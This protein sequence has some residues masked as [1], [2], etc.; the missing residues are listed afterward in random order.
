MAPPA[1]SGEPK[2][3]Q[4][5]ESGSVILEVMVTNTDPAKTKW[6]LNDKEL[7]ETESYAF[8]SKDEGGKRH[9]LKCEIKNFDKPLAG[10][11]KATFYST[12][13]E[14]SASFTVQ[15]GNAPDF[16]DKPHIVQRD[17]GNILCIKARAKSPTEMT[18]QWYKND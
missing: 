10:I 13:G 17:G 18:A 11:Y 5:T 1:I 4:D 6:F 12:D 8:S 7:A 2:I 14:N 15:A 3:T 9:T 16:Y